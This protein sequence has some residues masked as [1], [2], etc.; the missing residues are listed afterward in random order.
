MTPIIARLSAVAAL[1]AGM[2]L[3]AAFPASAAN[4]CIRF[5]DLERIQMTDDETAVAITS[6]ESFLVKFQPGCTVR[7]GASHFILE[8][9]RLG[10]CL[11]DGAVLST[12]D[13]IDCVVTSIA[14]LRDIPLEQQ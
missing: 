10:L 11:Q 8:Q 9:A 14:P 1:S 13:R 12:S 3:V 7:S 2:I 6:R 4:V 5:S